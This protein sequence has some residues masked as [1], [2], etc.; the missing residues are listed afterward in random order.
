MAIGCTWVF[1]PLIW[2]VEFLN[3]LFGQD[4]LKVSHEDDVVFAVE[5]YPAVVAIHGIVALR[6]AG[7]RAVEDV[8]ERLMMDITKYDIKILTE[9]HVTVAMDNKTTHDTLTAQAQMSVA[10]LVVE[11]HKVIVFLRL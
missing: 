5:V 11:C 10:P 6:L 3:K 9:G 2:A 7:F 4:S 8:I 1:C